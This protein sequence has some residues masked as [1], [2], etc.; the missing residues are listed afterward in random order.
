MV[1]KRSLDGGKTWLPMRIVVKAVPEAAM[2]PCPVID[3]STGSVILVIGS[4]TAGTACRNS[5]GPRPSH[6]PT[7]LALFKLRPMSN[8]NQRM[9][10]TFCS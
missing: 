6:L 10:L 2:D 4:P 1:L 5:S 9:I 8:L 7:I 3:R